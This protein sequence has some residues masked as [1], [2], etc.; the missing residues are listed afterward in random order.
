MCSK[1]RH[2]EGGKGQ[3]CLDFHNIIFSFRKKKIWEHILE[4]VRS[5]QLAPQTSWCCRV[6]THTHTRKLIGESAWCRHHY[7]PQI[8]VLFST[9]VLWSY[10]FATFQKILESDSFIMA[11]N[12][13]LPLFRMS[14]QKDG[15]LIIYVFFNIMPCIPVGHALS[16]A[17]LPKCHWPPQDP[18]KWVM[19]TQSGK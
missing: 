19:N 11:Y 2:W 5:H 9:N 7:T 15:S 4:V 14:S 1:R 3:G 17:Q 6:R 10:S 12:S 18:R 13:L 8:S 16:T